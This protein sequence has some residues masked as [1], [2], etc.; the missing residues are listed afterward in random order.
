M[1]VLT[2]LTCFYFPFNNCAAEFPPN[3]S[4][5]DRHKTDKVNFLNN[6]PNLEPAADVG[7]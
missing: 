5:M 2:S 4:I 7:L 3:L 6:D 1:Y